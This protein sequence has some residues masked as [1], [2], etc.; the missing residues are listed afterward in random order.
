MRGKARSDPIFP[1]ILG[2]TVIQTGGLF[3][4]KVMNRNLSRNLA[5]LQALLLN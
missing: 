5:V 4:R 1:G 3:R 2:V